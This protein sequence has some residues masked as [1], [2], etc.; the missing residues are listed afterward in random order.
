M[1]NAM[2][3]GV[4]G[5]GNI[6]A[7]YFEAGRKFRNIEIV[8]AADLHLE[9]AQA[10]AEQ[11]GIPKACAVDDLLADPDVEIVINL[12]VPAAHYGV[13]L[14]ALQ[15]GKHVYVEK[16]FSATRE[17]G[18]RLLDLAAEKG[19]RI[20]GAPDTFL[21]GGLQTCRKIL[22]DGWIGRPVAATAFVM[23]T[24]PEGW[25]P[26]PDFFYKA[27]GGPMFD[28]GPYY[29]TALV[30]LLGPIQRISG[31]ARRTHPERTATSEALYGRKIPVEIP[32]HVAGTLD[33]ESGPV[34]SMIMSFDVHAHR[35]PN[36]EI[37]GAEGTLAV[38]DPNCFDGPALVRRLD[39]REWRE[40]PLAFGYRENSRGIGVADMIDAIQSG[41]AHRASGELT[42]HVLEAM[43]GFHE[44]SESGRSYEMTSGCARPAPLKMGPLHDCAEM[45]A[46]R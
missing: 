18:K 13:C 16:P 1:I 9:R 33:F 46:F 3:V 4:I 42:Y 12:T 38:P 15:A 20:G 8:A 29:L 39:D 27:G 23:N 14:S 41:R 30:S 11:F 17:Q 40:T 25:H 10:R 32:T 2:K 37:Y 22:D 44:A 19:L 35:L 24:G 5:C 7:I 43:H 26:S 6:S 28:M 34:A 45:S 31:S 36:I 21:G